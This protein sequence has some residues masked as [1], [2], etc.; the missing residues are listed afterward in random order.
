MTVDE[1]L[2]TALRERHAMTTGIVKA[3]LWLNDEVDVFAAK[4]LLAAF[5]ITA[6][7][8][9]K[10]DAVERIEYYGSDLTEALE[11]LA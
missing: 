1:Q 3:A 8:M 10:A 11:L 2:E 9:R 5:E 7:D 4:R 6:E